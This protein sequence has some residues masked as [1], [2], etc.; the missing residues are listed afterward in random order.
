ML[1]IINI[2]VLGVLAVGFVGAAYYL[3]KMQSKFTEISTEMEEFKTN[4]TKLSELADKVNALIP[5]AE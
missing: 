3:K 4:I 1:T 5:S 2:A